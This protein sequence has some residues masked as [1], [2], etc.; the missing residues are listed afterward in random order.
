MI[1]KAVLILMSARLYPM[2]DAKT[3]FV[4]TV[5]A[6]LCAS[7]I[8]AT[9]KNLVIHCHVLILM[10]AQVICAVVHHKL[11]LIPLDHIGVIV[12]LV[13]KKILPVTALILT[14]VQAIMAAVIISV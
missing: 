8:K 1:R 6:A 13:I 4:Q 14:N 7:V 5:M 12:N 9:P 11:V 3:H 2:V 10:N